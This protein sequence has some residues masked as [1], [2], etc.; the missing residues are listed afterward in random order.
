[1][2]EYHGSCQ[3]GAVTFHADLDLENGA[4]T[5]NCSRCRRLG[6]RLVFTPRAMFT[7]DSGADS[8]T[9]YK[10][11]RN[12]IA[13]QFCKVCGIEP[14]GYG[15]MPDGSAMTAVNINVLDGIDPAAIK[16]TMYD[17]ASS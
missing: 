15:Q 3:C 4:I 2:T 8:L 10:F 17:G 6:S 11:N 13:H 1:M 12:V 5:C 7:L 16:T 9:E 14:F